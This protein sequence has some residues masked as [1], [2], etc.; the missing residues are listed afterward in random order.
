[1]VGTLVFFI[2][3]L[4]M[5]SFLFMRHWELRRDRRMF[6]GFRSRADKIV[7]GAHAALEARMPKLD[8]V[9]IA[10]AYH[11][12]V[13]A[14]ALILLAVL[15]LTERQVMKVL[16]YVRGKRELPRMQT[17]SA[18]LKEVSAHKQSLEKPARRAIE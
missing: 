9:F 10:R 1:M 13:H 8:S 6:E 2:S 5:V 14:C 18:F 11:S 15:K 7:S 3:L 17:Q 12:L 4:G 16:E